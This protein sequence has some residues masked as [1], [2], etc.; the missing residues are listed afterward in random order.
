[1]RDIVLM[2]VC[3]S[4]LVFGLILFP[5][6]QTLN[7]PLLDHSNRGSLSSLLSLGLSDAYLPPYDSSLG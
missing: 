2:T 4:L 7:N 5:P 6:H 1:M 3:G